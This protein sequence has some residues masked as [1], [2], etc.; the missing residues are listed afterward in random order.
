MIY[1]FLMIYYIGNIPRYMYMYINL[2]I[3]RY[4]FWNIRYIRYSEIYQL[5]QSYFLVDR[6]LKLQKIPRC[7]NIDWVIMSSTNVVMSAYFGLAK[8]SM[9]LN[10][11]IKS[12]NL[13]LIFRSYSTCKV[14]YIVEHSWACIIARDFALAR[15]ACLWSCTWVCSCPWGSDLGSDMFSKFSSTHCSSVPALIIIFVCISSI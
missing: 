15:I 12:W 3:F 4:I 11:I 7:P 13:N 2:D 1:R 9:V 8:P 10:R 6:Y 5:Y 14:I